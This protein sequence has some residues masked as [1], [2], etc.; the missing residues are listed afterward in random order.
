MVGFERGCLCVVCEVLFL[1]LRRVSEGEDRET[2]RLEETD[3]ISQVASRMT[4][5]SESI[6]IAGKKDHV[7]FGFS[8][9]CVRYHTT[10]THPMLCIQQAKA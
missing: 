3:N 8:Q 2:G 9:I 5:F 10:A 1:F 6:R 4:D 7:L